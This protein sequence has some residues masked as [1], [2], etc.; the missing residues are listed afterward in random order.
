[1][2]NIVV[3]G[4]QWGDE[5]KGKVVDVLSGNA[6]AVVRFQGGHNAGHT[7]KVGGEQRI[8]H[9]IPSGA[10]HPN[11]ECI[12]GGGVVLSVPA[13]LEEIGMLTDAGIDIASKLKI[14]SLCPLVLSCHQHLDAARES[15]RGN[16]SI[17][18][19]GKGIGP[20]YEDKVARRALRVHHLIDPDNLAQQMEELF[21]YHNFSL[22]K[23]HGQQALDWRLD[24]EQIMEHREAL[25]S[26]MCEVPERLEQLYHA[27]K[28]ILFE[29]AQGS[30]LDIDHGTYPFVTSSQTI[31]GHITCGAGF[32]ANLINHT[33]GVCKAYTTRVGNGP[34]PTELFDAAGQHMADVGKE[35]GATTGRPRRCGWLDLVMLKKSLWLNGVDVL[36]LT[37]LDVLE[38]LESL[39][40]CTAY[41]NPDAPLEQRKPCYTELSGWNE[42]ITGV[43][44]YEDL[45]QAVRDYIEFIQD[46]TGVSVGVIST[47]AKREESIVRTPLFKNT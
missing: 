37:K 22:E 5:G 44:R 36:C 10:L 7:L 11:T 34:F 18:T 23:Y 6:D 29:G 8:L 26:M 41:E 46:Q 3:V 31:A 30:M 13:L 1:M 21:A 12:I 27:H 2:S 16:N 35:F 28:H 25:M 20:A 4:L 32:P 33:V 19:T 47:G 39:K 38:G 24:Y 9:L 14:S 17:G 43:E 42:P 40:I 15:S 45:P